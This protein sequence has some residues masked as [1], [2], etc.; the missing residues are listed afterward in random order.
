MVR[1][2]TWNIIN[3]EPHQGILEAALSSLFHGHYVIK[4]ARKKVAIRN[5]NTGWY[6]EVDVWYPDLKICFEYQDDYHY[7]SSWYSQYPLST[8]QE[9]D[10]IKRDKLLE[11]GESLIL[12][13]CWWD[14][15]T[16]S[17][18][19][20]INFHRPDLLALNPS[21][22][23]PGNPPIDFFS[24]ASDSDATQ[25]MLASFP[26][27]EMVVGTGKNAW[28][29]GEKYDG[30]R[31][32]WNPQE[33]QMYSRHGLY[34]E[35]H[36]SVNSTLGSVMLD[37][38]IWSGRGLFL[39]SQVAV[40]ST[41]KRIN[42]GLLRIAC[43]DE[44][45][46]LMRDR[47]FEERYAHIL[48]HYPV[49]HPSI[50]IAPR[51]QCDSTF[52]LTSSLQYIVD[53]GG[54][55]IILRKPNSLYL[56][57]RSASLLKVKA[58]QSDHEALVVDVE[59]DGSL[60]LQLPNG[61]TFLVEKEDCMLP[62]RAV[63]GDVVTFS[64]DFSRR[65]VQE[66]L[67]ETQVLHTAQGHSWTQD[68]VREA[69]SRPV[70]SRIRVDLSWEDVVSSSS[71]PVRH[72]S[73]EPYQKLE[74]NAPKP[75][76]HWN[77][78]NMR[79]LLESLARKDGFDPLV[80][81]SWYSV[82]FQFALQHK[83][84]RP[85]LQYFGNSLIKAVVAL[86]PELNL[87]VTKFSNSPR[88]HWESAQNRRALLENF[89]RS[90]GSDPLSPDFWYTLNPAELSPVKGMSAIKEYYEGY[91]DTVV[92]LFPEIHFEKSKFSTRIVQSWKDE[93]ERRRYFDKFAASQGFDPLNPVAWSRV[94]VGDLKLFHPGYRTILKYYGGKLS[95]CLLQLYPDIGLEMPHFDAQLSYTKKSDRKS[96]LLRFAEKRSF[97]PLNAENWYN[98]SW[99]DFS[100]HYLARS[101]ITH[102]YQRKYV[103]ALMDLFPELDLNPSKFANIP[104]GHWEE[105][106]NRRKLFIEIARE[107][108]FDPLV[109]SN[110]YPVSYNSLINVRGVTSVLDHYYGGSLAK[111][112]VDIFPEIGLVLS[113]FQG[114][115]EWESKE[116]RRWYLESVAKKQR[117]DPLQPAV[118]SSF[119][120]SQKPSR[121]VAKTITR[122][123]QNYATTVDAIGALF[124]EMSKQDL[125][126]NFN[127]QNQNSL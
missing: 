108:G 50:I 100:S 53:G 17:L 127:Q 49:D 12:V 44:A 118:W 7:Q 38:E 105:M 60:L 84:V 35:V 67:A 10:N 57:G 31:C 115:K 89:A 71:V 40:T 75:K 123:F 32:F 29:L 110:W 2:R 81:D 13:P 1:S 46:Q 74:K 65:I 87:D 42:W 70:V 18:Q 63:R 22:I 79:I 102:C 48:S 77:T 68:V 58:T 43:F 112:V 4:N 27:S 6:L 111:A 88:S 76:G 93:R 5:P 104:V 83:E 85:M 86:F 24:S 37:G 54:E 78:N 64:L 25:L 126:R 96:I 56:Y 45:S 73:N 19:A 36:P 97:D 16:T 69:P 21:S 119:L 9:K 3:D 109:P 117:F 120:S 33:K 26:S 125:A 92:H 61:T 113:E 122:I 39:E 55:G 94:S 95:A 20:T 121:I 80:A 66:P 91:V 103:S 11:R 52:L 106:A 47:P 14:G 72:F 59:D 124:P 23:I 114:G 116:A 28:W 8:I 34:I 30:V 15:T 98:T 82:T 51:F 90:K 41:L 107:R 99:A 62:R 101:M